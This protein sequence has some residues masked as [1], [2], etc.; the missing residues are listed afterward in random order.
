MTHEEAAA[1]TFGAVSALS[2]LRRA[3]IQTG[4]HVLIYGAS[5]SVGTFAVQ[6]AKHFGAHVT[7][8]CVGTACGLRAGVLAQ[9]AFRQRSVTQ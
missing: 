4:Q 3:K 5:G 9:V 1:V 2:F 6:L 8:V 7:G